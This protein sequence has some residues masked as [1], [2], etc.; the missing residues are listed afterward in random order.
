MSRAW[1][2]YRIV[3]C[4]IVLQVAAVMAT[5]SLPKE[6]KVEEQ[7]VDQPT[8]IFEEPQ[9]PT[10]SNVAGVSCECQLFIQSWKTSNLIRLSIG[11]NVIC[12]ETNTFR[13]VGT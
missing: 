7:A 5:D 13:L 9:T 8:P 12:I 3:L 1:W 4:L 6:L 11:K 10:T 2:T